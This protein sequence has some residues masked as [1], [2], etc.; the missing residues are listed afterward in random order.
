M[1]AKIHGTTARGDAATAGGPGARAMDAAHRGTA[2]HAAHGA[3]RTRHGRVTDAAHRG[4]ASREPPLSTLPR[5]ALLGAL[6]LT[7]GATSA[8]SKE[9]PTT[10]DV[11]KLPCTERR[12]TASFELPERYVACTQ[13]TTEIKLGP[14]TCKK[15]TTV[16][17]YENSKTLE[18][19][20]VAQPV[21]VD[22]VLCTGG[23]SL[24]PSGKLRRCQLEAQLERNGLTMPKG[25]WI[26][27][28]PES[29]N[30]RRI[31]LPQGGRIGPYSCRGY[32]NYAY[33]SG[34]PKKCELA[35][36]ATI[37]DKPRKA[38]EIVCF[39]E[40]GKSTDCSSLKL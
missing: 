28:Y 10:I 9:P 17:V 11:E 30:P 39:A 37:D 13:P 4:T 26:T 31:E 25:A 18:T 12:P 1:T 19:C 36:E 29:G 22:G 35:A 20:W 7:A 3:S 40:D 23:V 15:G 34:K 32:T 5:T 8:C 6:V 24:L 38:G 21:Q 14:Y 2:S 16:G 33:E 27:F